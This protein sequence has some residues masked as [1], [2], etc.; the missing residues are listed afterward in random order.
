MEITECICFEWRER[1]SDAELVFFRQA[2]K[3]N[4]A[5]TITA[6]R[7]PELEA[8]FMVGKAKVE[9]MKARLFAR[10]R[11]HFQRRDR[12]A[13]TASPCTRTSP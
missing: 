9:A 2:G 3:R 8:G 12:P 6:A 1:G 4:L 7:L 10:L 13:W 11:E 5:V